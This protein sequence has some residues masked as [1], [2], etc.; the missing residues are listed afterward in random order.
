MVE[1]RAWKAHNTSHIAGDPI[2]EE[3]I[4]PGRF[5]FTYILYINYNLNI[6]NSGWFNHVLML[7]NL[8]INRR[9][10]LLLR[11]RRDI[12]QVHVTFGQ[13]P[14]N[15]VERTAHSGVTQTS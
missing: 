5:L 6:L 4:A 2:V 12:K 8:D 1:Q 7:L 13:L 15:L 11:T 9:F 3:Y 14:L 10:C